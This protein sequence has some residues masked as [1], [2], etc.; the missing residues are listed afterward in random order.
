MRWAGHVA[1]IG[2]RRG[3]CRVL[4]GRLGVKRPLGRTKS[5][6]KDIIKMDLQEVGWGARIGLN[7]LRIG[8]SGGHL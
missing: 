4:V 2:D 6:W 5:R 3:A 1:C 8:T 7:W